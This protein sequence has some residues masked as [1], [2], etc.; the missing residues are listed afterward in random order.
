RPADG[1]TSVHQASASLVNIVDLIGEVTEIASAAV[2]RLVPIVGEFDFAAVIVWNP[3]EDK[4]VAARF[5]VH[6]PPLLE[7]EQ[8]KECNSGL[9][10][11]GAEHRMQ[12]FHFISLD[13]SI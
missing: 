9:R 11:R 13:S 3:E 2:T 10:I 4:R 6:S 8:L 1:D 12:K 5:I 7:P